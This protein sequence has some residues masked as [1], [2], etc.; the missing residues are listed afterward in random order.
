MTRAEVAEASTIPGRGINSRCT[1]T[2][3]AILKALPPREQS[4]KRAWELS[5]KRG[6]VQGHH[7]EDWFRAER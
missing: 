7:L 2:L 6:R 5:F 4:E 3:S 1:S